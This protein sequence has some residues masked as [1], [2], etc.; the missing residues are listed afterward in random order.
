MLHNYRYFILLTMVPASL[1]SMQN[2]VNY[3]YQVL[4]NQPAY[5]ELETKFGRQALENVLYNYDSNAYQ[6]DSIFQNWSS[7]AGTV[8]GYYGFEEQRRYFLTSVKL[9]S[10]T[11]PKGLQV[12][13]D[14]FQNR[15]RNYGHTN[16]EN[17]TPQ[18]YIDTKLQFDDY[19]AA[20]AI[21]DAIRSRIF[22]NGISPLV[23]VKKTENELSPATKWS[24]FKAGA[25]IMHLISLCLEKEKEEKNKKKNSSLEG[26]LAISDVMQRAEEDIQRS[27]EDSYPIL[28]THIVKS[29]VDDKTWWLYDRKNWIACGSAF[30]MMLLL[31]CLFHDKIPDMHR[32]Y[33]VIIVA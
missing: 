3:Q 9:H 20:K 23:L 16:S 14:C 33:S 27:L 26:F 32:I 13:Y 15:L 21:S 6:C 2:I 31:Y 12:L 4:L 10:I 28:K 25:V 8:I 24:I 17:F 30:C 18:G 7:V 22:V 1:L 29:L 11:N 5:K 19:L